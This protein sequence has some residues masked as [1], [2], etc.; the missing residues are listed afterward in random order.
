MIVTES[1]GG[2]LPSELDPNDEGLVYGQKLPYVW[3][4]LERI[5][6]QLGLTPLGAFAYRDPELFEEMGE[7]PPEQ[8]EWHEP[9]EAHKTV[10]GLLRFFQEADAGRLGE[11][12]L[13][14]DDHEDI[15]WDLSAYEAILRSA[16]KDGD[17]LRIEVG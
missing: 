6:Q 15:V 2:D 5:A 3:G 11:F 8:E 7:E 9:A 16:S 17:R 4:E 13:S 12:G 14:A 1:G 10:T